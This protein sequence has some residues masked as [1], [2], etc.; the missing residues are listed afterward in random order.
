MIEGACSCTYLTLR[1]EK[2]GLG[3]RSADAVS[4]LVAGRKKHILQTRS[5]LTCVMCNKDG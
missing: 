5:G 1:E 4:H 2:G 3:I